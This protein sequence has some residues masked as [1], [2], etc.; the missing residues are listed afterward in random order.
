MVK[1]SREQLYKWVWSCPVIR[2]AEEVGIS[3]S[4]LAKKCKRYNI[5]APGRGYWLQV[6]QGKN[7]RCVPL[8]DPDMG[9]TEVPVN[10]SEER[11]AELDQLPAPCVDSLTT[12]MA[13]DNAC[14]GLAMPRVSEGSKAPKVAAVRGFA[15]GMPRPQV[16]RAEEGRQTI[17]DPADIIAL[18][19]LH[20]KSESAR[21]F[22]EALRE[23]S[24]DCDASTKAVLIL[25]TDAARG[26]ISQSDP[27]AQIIQECRHVA[28]GKDNPGWWNS[29]QQGNGGHQ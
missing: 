23:A 2:I 16:G 7:V 5:P 22:M 27:I 10:V 19:T 20:D 15:S 3:D 24:R 25:W 29:I 6:K 1:L 14:D 9:A 8:P 18:A 28:S 21:R 4:A 11:A 12:P 13:N 26:A 17:A